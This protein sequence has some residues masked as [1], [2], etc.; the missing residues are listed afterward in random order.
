MNYSKYSNSELSLDALRTFAP[1]VFADRPYAEMSSKYTFIPTIDVVK[2]LQA[3]GFRPFKAMEARTRIE[4][5]AG[6]TKHMIRFRHVSHMQAQNMELGGLIPEI[7]LTNSHDGA[8]AFKVDSGIFRLVC[9]NGLMVGDTFG[10]YKARHSGKIG[11]IIEA[12]FEVIDE[13]PRAIEAARQFAELRLTA[14]QQEAFGAAAIALRWEDQAPVTPAQIVAPRRSADGE[15]NLWN[16]LN[17]AQERLIRGGTPGVNAAGRR[18]RTREV[19]GIDENRR[20]NK[21]LW[22]LAERMKE[23]V[24]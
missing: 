16:T 5:K 7:V 2:Q 18:A 4:E 10:S 20:I 11:D 12:A 24:S 9:T 14:G 8:S 15:K 6:F 23:L 17:V 3:E 1:S 19:S 22:I 21:A 13:S